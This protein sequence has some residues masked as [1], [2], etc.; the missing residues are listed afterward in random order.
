MKRNASLIGS[1][2]ISRDEPKAGKHAKCFD[3]YEMMEEYVL[4]GRYPCDPNEQ[5]YGG[6]RNEI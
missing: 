6:S 4:K 3:F 1:K 5:S 2:R